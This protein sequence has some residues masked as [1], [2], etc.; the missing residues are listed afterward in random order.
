MELVLSYHFVLRFMLR[1]ATNP[2]ASR[3]EYYMDVDCSF[4]T[5][6]ISTAETK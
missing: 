4:Y 6:F 1:A 3:K 2:A 5:E